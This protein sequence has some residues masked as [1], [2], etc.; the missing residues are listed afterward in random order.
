[1]PLLPS[2]LASI[3]TM[4]QDMI[5]GQEDGYHDG[6]FLSALKKKGILKLADGKRWVLD[7]V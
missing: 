7:E 3:H 5:R 4:M 2:I 6:I 1:M